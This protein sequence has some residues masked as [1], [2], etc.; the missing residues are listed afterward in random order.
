MLIDFSFC[1]SSPEDDTLGESADN[2]T[3]RKKNKRKASISPIV[4]S[5]VKK[6]NKNQ[7]IKINDAI[8]QK[9][10]AIFFIIISL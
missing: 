5:N 2:V 1:L 10:Q 9:I 4:Y 3:K 8:F 7:N 6:V